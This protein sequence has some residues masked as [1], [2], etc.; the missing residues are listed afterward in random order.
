MAVAEL[1]VPRPEPEAAWRPRL[2]AILAVLAVGE[3]V[4]ILL[5]GSLGDPRFVID[6]TLI[7]IGFL[8]NVVL[9]PTVGALI[10]QRRPR[11]RVAWLMSGLGLSIGFG[12]LAY[13]YGIVG[14]GRE[15]SFPLALPLLV[16]SQ[17][18]FVPA[19]GGTTAWILLLYPTDRLLARRWGWFGALAI[20]GSAAFVV[21]TLFLPGDLDAT[22][23]PGV[24]NPLGIEGEAGA[25]LGVIAQAGNLLTLGALVG[26]VSSLV[27]RYRRA[28]PVVAAQIRWL[29]LV[30]VLAIASLASSLVPIGNGAL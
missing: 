19:I 2:A 30:A 22:A 1:T 8:S 23:A 18:F 14:Q 9:F 20:A 27:V 16:A 5:L 10:L 15:R 28:D 6:L 7:P 11:T 3:A 25:W 13:A 21:G 17:L 29:A 12:L 24:R 4:G 26:C